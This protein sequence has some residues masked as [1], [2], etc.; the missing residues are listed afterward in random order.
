[1]SNEIPVP[2]EKQLIEAYKTLQSWCVYR[3][4]CREPERCPFFMIDHSGCAA[5]SPQRWPDIPDSL[6]SPAP[7][8]R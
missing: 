4:S 8:E 7:L 1:M 3:D 5:E 2:T 6:K